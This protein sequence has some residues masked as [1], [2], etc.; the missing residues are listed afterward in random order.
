[1]LVAATRSWADDLEEALARG[2]GRGAAAASCSSATATRSRRPTAP[3][4]W[5]ARR[6][7][8]SSTSRSCRSADGLGISLYRPLEAGPRMLRAKLFRAG[9][10]ADALGRAPAV[11][12]H[13]RGGRRRAPL[14]DRPA[15]PRR[16]L[17]LRLR[18]HLRRRGRPRARAA[19]AR[20]SRTPSCA[21]GAA[22]SRT[23]A[24]TGSCSAPRSPGARSRCCARSASTCA[25]RGITFS[26]PY[27]EQALVA[28]PE[29]ARLLVA[30][31]QARFDPRRT[32]RE[33]AEEVAERI[34]RG[35]RRRGEPRPGPD[36]ADVPR[37]DPRDPAHELL[38]DRPHR[39]GEP[40]LVQARPARRCAGCRSRARATRSSS[41]R[42]APRA[43]TCAAARWRAAASAGPTGARTSAPRCSA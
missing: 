31:F 24:T 2:A 34:E 1:M 7:P 41:T 11:R 22:T 25:R 13:G 35:D 10:A 43:C 39:G 38:P 32:D 12:E 15:R 4:G 3:T 19:S 17:D 18:A 27:V 20:A 9:R 37:G 40:P 28:H 8:T 36:P 5:R 14:P 21:R 6:S 16:R 30:L 26:D 42:R 23:T 29:I 33:D